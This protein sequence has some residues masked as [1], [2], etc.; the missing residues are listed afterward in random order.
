M[1]PHLKAFPAISLSLISLAVI[2]FGATLNGGAAANAATSAGA[3]SMSSATA[4]TVQ[5]YGVRRIGVNRL[6]GSLG[7]ASVLCSTANNTAVAGRDYTAISRVITWASGDATEKWCDIAISN[8]TPFSGQKTL[9]V[10]L[11]SPTGA[12]LGTVTTTEVTIYGDKG[13]GLVSL[14]APTYTVAQNAGSVTIT[15]NR[16]NGSV[17]AA[18]LNYATANSTAIA[19]IDYT[20]KRGTLGWTNADV[21][22]KKI[23]IPISN[24]RP[25]TGTKKLAIAIAGAENVSLGTTTSAIVTING[26]AT[27]A[28]PNVSLSATPTSVASGEG[29]TVTWSASNAT[30]CTASGG[31]TG[32]MPTSGSKA[33]GALSSSAT[34]SLTCTGAGGSATQ[35]TTVA[36]SSTPP[37]ASASCTGSSGSLNLKAT[38]VRGAGISPFLVFFDATGTTDSSIRGNTTAFQDVSYSWNFGDTGASGTDTWAYGSNRGHNSRNRATGGVAAHLYVTPGVDTAYV[39]TVTA[40]N[41]TNTASCQLGVTA[42]DPAG[43]NG[44]A[45]TNTTCVS[46]SGTPTPGAGGCPAGAA[47]L[48]TSSFNTALGSHMGS[49]KR[50]LFKCGDTFSGDSAMI[51]GTRW[52]VGAYGGC[53]GTQTNRPILSD[54]GSGGELYIAVHSG[55]GRVADLDL[56]GNGR[57]AVGVAVPAGTNIV[58][59]QLTLSNLRSNGNNVSYTTPQ[60]AQVGIVESV[61]TGM[62]D[63]GVFINNGGNNPAT[64]SGP[65]PADNYEALLGN[66]FNGVGAGSGAGIETVRIAACRFCVIENNTIEN[67]N[68]VGGVLKLHNGNPSSTTAWTGVY[69]EFVEISDNLFTG[70]S[71]AQLVENAPQNST[72]DERL[73]NIVVERNVFSP[74]G[75]GGRQLQVS[76]V[77]ETVRNNVFHSTS[78][79]QSAFGVQAARRGMEPAP[80]G[81][82]IYNNTCDHVQTC[83]ALDG[84]TESAPANNSYAKNNLNYNPAGGTTVS[85]TGSGNAVSNNTVSPTS[86]PDFTNGSGTFSVLSDFRPRA[87][88]LGGTI[89]PVYTDALG[90][91]WGLTWDL[92]AVHP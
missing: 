52:S 78:S 26:D 53:E 40:H 71:G 24:A 54:S 77:N 31:W 89:V 84:V 3:I 2:F 23:V 15:V 74:A 55:D 4:G 51:S 67:A 18:S 57:G 34:Y 69:T 65:F 90:L 7:A 30:A 38:A 75:A 82:E 48:T 20:S 73:R 42:H 32:P 10:K 28:Q 45:G 29:A 37:P 46:A 61:M 12:P 6:G 63:I 76:A 41:G 13:G 9:F 86:N 50:V 66:S 39:V 56:E 35:S 33:T 19:G 25:F 8:T 87:N 70:T 88:Y 5:N 59:Y 22:P 11:S 60:G 64:W 81:V 68:Y 21:T 85:N 16:T 17:G 62:R 49:G 44:F 79:S 36:V 72:T 1:N 14:S 83:V 92:G 91:L 58:P 80:S 47:T 27:T 43:A